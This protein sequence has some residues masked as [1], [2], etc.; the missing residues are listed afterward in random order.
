M[1]CFKTFSDISAFVSLSTL[2]DTSAFVSS[3]ALSSDLST[4]ASLDLLSDSSSFCYFSSFWSCS[5]RSLEMLKL[6]SDWLQKMTLRI[7][8]KFS[9][10]WWSW[11]RIWNCCLFQS[12]SNLFSRSW[13]Q[14]MSMS[15]FFSCFF[16]QYMILK[17]N[18]EK[19]SAQW[20]CWWFNCLIVMK[21]FRFL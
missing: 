15:D 20:I 12:S 5:D 7:F 9:S 4:N 1:S 19:N 3:S 10:S 2:S 16:S 17:L 18:S 14:Q 6:K 8:F 21:C 11:S 13:D